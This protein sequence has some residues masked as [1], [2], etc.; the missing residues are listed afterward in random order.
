MIFITHMKQSIGFLTLSYIV[1]L[2]YSANAQQQPSLLLWNGVILDKNST[3]IY[4]SNP[5]GGIDAIEIATGLVKWHSDIAESPIMLKDAQLIAQADSQIANNLSLK[6][7]DTSTGSSTQNKQLPLPSKVH[8]PISAELNQKF[9]I[10]IDYDSNPNGD[11]NWEY[12][13]KLRQGISP[14]KPI[15]AQYTYGKIAIRDSSLL[16]NASMQIQQQ[17]HQNPNKH[18]EGTFLN[19]LK[20][21]AN[22]RQFISINSQH[23][24][25]S[26][27][28][29]KPSILN[30]Y[31]WE[32]YDRNGQLQGSLNNSVSYSPFL[33]SGQTIVFI[34]QPYSKSTKVGLVKS[35]LSLQ[36]YS[37]ETGKR[38]WT[39]EIRDFRYLGPYP[40]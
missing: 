7:L 30:S 11:I 9:D 40:P 27:R 16:N 29:E 13:Y 20:S 23:I 15:K 17:K 3:T 21:G 28:K 37:L 8:A 18:I 24:L 26:K 38:L 1:L 4:A 32:I 25:L 10:W 35:P 31:I 5:N 2:S 19:N 22:N 14:V 39:K 33:V 34:T 36:A 12:Y 6:T